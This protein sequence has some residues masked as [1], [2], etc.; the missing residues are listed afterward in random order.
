MTI[1]SR[2]PPHSEMSPGRPSKL[3]KWAASKVVSRNVSRS[4]WLSV[5]S[6]GGAMIVRTTSPLGRNCSYPPGKNI[7]PGVRPRNTVK[8]PLGCCFVSPVGISPGNSRYQ[9]SCPVE[10]KA[11]T[12]PVCPESAIAVRT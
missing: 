1:V 7:Q 4:S 3:K 11:T 10:S 12:K 6:G 9:R 8:S 2:G 5:Y